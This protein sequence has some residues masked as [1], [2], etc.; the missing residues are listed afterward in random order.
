[1]QTTHARTVSPSYFHWSRHYL[2][3]IPLRGWAKSLQELRSKHEK[4]GTLVVLLAADC[5]HHLNSRVTVEFPLYN[6]INQ[7]SNVS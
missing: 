3:C 2:L 7:P 5:P 4:I 6:A 1:M